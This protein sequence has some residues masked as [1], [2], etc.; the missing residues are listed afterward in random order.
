MPVLVGTP[1]APW[2]EGLTEPHDVVV[3]LVLVVDASGHV[4][5]V[6]LEASVSP[7]LDQAAIRTAS[8]WTFVP[9]R[10]GETPVTARVRAFVRFVGEPPPAPPLEPAESPEEPP[11]AA[12]ARV[13]EPPK[14]QA[15]RP[16]DVV[17]RGAPVA[18]TGSETRLP[19][20]ALDAAPHRSASDLLAVA[21]GVAIT[22]HGGQ[23]KA[24]QIFLRGFDAGHG[25]EVEV[26][27]A[28]APV[29]EV[30]NVH[31]QGYADLHFVL[32]EVVR[33]VRATAGPWD[34]RQGDFA[35]AG[36]FELDLGY[37]EPGVHSAV[38][39][40]SFGER[41][42]F[43]VVHPEGTP[44]G[45]FAAFEAQATEGFGPSRSAQKTA[46][47]AQGS[48]LLGDGVEARVTASAYA[49]A[50]ASAGVVRQSDLTT[51]RV[52][53]FGTY[54]RAQGGA[55]SRAQLSAELTRAD[56]DGASTWSVAPYGVART[57]RLRSNY[58][59][60]L[61][62]PELGD[63]IEQRNEA[64]TLGARG[65]H[66]RRLSLLSDDDALEVGFSARHDWIEQSDGFP[67][68][69]D[70]RGGEPRVDAS[71][72]ALDLGS[73]VELAVRPAPRLALRGGVRVDGVALRAADRVPQANARDGL[74]VHVGKKLSAELALTGALHA[75][76]SY[77]EGFRSPEARSVQEGEDLRF[78][79]VRSVETSLRYAEGTRTRATLSGFASA[80]G[81]DLVFDGA[82]AR[83][84]PVPP[85]RRLGVAIDALVRPRP[86]LV[87]SASFTYVR[88]TFTE[89]NDAFAAGSPVPYA[90]RLVA[91]ADLGA[92]PVVGRWMGREVS[93]HAGS[94]MSLLALR[95]LPRVGGFAPD[96]LLVDLTL[97][98]RVG[99]V[100]LRFDAWNALDAA[101]Y[102]GAFVYASSFTKGAPKDL[103]PDTH[104][105]EGAPRT[106][107]GTLILHL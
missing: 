75:L 94:G 99:E 37:A 79:E 13:P 101:W 70:G 54:D 25:Q 33:Q 64:I 63:A 59:G 20:A 71:V 53:R 85:S 9:A 68:D 43:V 32:P 89:G 61:E 48:F 24:H 7:T 6:E 8:G 98:A 97:G 96:A 1:V 5:E 95:P 103:V 69:G 78:T 60:Y 77:G 11:A 35:V 23:G 84:E 90:P 57:L 81:E 21:P 76:A 50:F 73:Y 45:T 39:Y 16:I 29:N 80:L 102:D 65:H 88:G 62:R 10:R 47:I 34:V 42:Y 107:L 2:P 58:T 106:V 41:R 92:T 15:P 38:S 28:G 51:G 40:G 55:S 46:G 4:R 19:R 66:R 44:E 18:R 52:P 74:G 105:T 82:S 14:T 27:V 91:R 100:E 93:L 31:E 72:R 56:A 49:S 36:S 104:V 67:A 12:P 17:V 30:S 87:S 86:W 83:S 26:W 3:P 22:Q